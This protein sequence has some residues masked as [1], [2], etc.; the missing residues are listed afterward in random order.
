MSITLIQ[1]ITNH[2]QEIHD[3]I[4]FNPEKDLLTKNICQNEKELTNTKEFYSSKKVCNKTKILFL[5]Y[6]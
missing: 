6:F 2:S 5:I 4:D 1:K 3:K